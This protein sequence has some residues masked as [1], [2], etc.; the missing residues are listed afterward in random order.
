MSVGRG[1]ERVFFSISGGLDGGRDP[2]WMVLPLFSSGYSRRLGSDP[3]RECVSGE[4]HKDQRKSFIDVSALGPSCS[5]TQED[6][7]VQTSACAAH[8]TFDPLLSSTEGSLHPLRL[9]LCFLPHASFSF[10]FPL[11]FLPLPK[12]EFF[13]RPLLAHVLTPTHLSG[14]KSVWF[15]HEGLR[16]TTA[17]SSGGNLVRA[18]SLRTA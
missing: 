6:R 17:D 11:F 18:A 1:A 5:H 8:G 3:H 14:P 4:G 15:Q 9:S 12:P 7:Q 10:S 16:V 2:V 13:A